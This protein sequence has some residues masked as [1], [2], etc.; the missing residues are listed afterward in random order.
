[1]SGRGG[2]RGSCSS[3]SSGRSIH[4]SSEEPVVPAI[5]SS[6]LPG[7]RAANFLQQASTS[8][9]AQRLG[10]SSDTIR[11][12]ATSM[13]QDQLYTIGNAGHYIKLPKDRVEHQEHGDTMHEGVEEF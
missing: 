2:G 7:S 9:V 8:S 12:I 5:A 13:A 3:G 10:I 4:S 1:M 11:S 6:V